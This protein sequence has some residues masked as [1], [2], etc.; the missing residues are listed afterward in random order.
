[1]IKKL[2]R[3]FVVMLAFAA[4]TTA[5]SFSPI[6]SAFA[7]DEA[8]AGTAAEDIQLDIDKFSNAAALVTPGYINVT[9]N[10]KSGTYD[11]TS[12]DVAG[13]LRIGLGG[14]DL[15]GAETFRFLMKSGKATRMKFGFID[16]NGTAVLVD[17]TRAGAYTGI[18]FL[19]YNS[20]PIRDTV[21][22]DL[23]YLGVRFNNTSNWGASYVCLS[24]S[25]FSNALS[26]TTSNG[27]AWGY[28]YS[29]GETGAKIDWTDIDS[30]F[31]EYVSN[32]DDVSWRN[33]YSLD[34]V[35]AEGVVETVNANNLTQIERPAY[36]A[37]DSGYEK[38][39]YSF[40]ARPVFIETTDFFS[41]KAVSCYHT[42]KGGITGTTGWLTDN[43]SRDLTD[44]NAI[45][46][47]VDTT[48][49]AITGETEIQWLIK[50]KDGVNYGGNTYS[51]RIPDGGDIQII[52]KRSQFIPAGYRGRIIIPFT[53]FHGNDTTFDQV[54]RDSVVK[55]LLAFITNGNGVGT[56]S[57]CKIIVK[58]ARY[59]ANFDEEVAAA[60]AAALKDGLAAFCTDFYM[61]DGASI[62]IK[63]DDFGLRF[64]INVG[65]ES[66]TAL[67]EKARNLGVNVKIGALL[68]PTV[69]LTEGETVCELTTQNA[70]ALLTA[71][72]WAV[73]NQ[74]FYA[75]LGYDMVKEH[76]NDEVTVRGYLVL[77]FKDGTDLTV[78]TQQK[79]D[80]EGNISGTGGQVS[81]S[82]MYVAQKVDENFSREFAGIS[83]DGKKYAFE[84]LKQIYPSASGYEP[85][86]R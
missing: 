31:I 48:D 67:K 74:R 38:N 39:E 59:I 22:E 55:T 79:K 61:R 15:S 63:K 80:A 45:S 4:A 43:V 69:S 12:K 30:V 75:T 57:S 40:G 5:C 64:E 85:N 68:A 70:A 56:D 81:R 72:K 3:F 82:V 73:E 16:G 6:L 34:S 49:P 54:E 42:V 51:V 1:M 21:A 58:D 20:E 47:C 14:A 26:F 44:Y 46:F 29:E 33:F 62:R 2:K 27:T 86:G 52:Y 11:A 19:N 76:L 10:K 28:G 7:I 78:Y 8:E 83:E 25:T 66:F 65:E 9:Q 13:T 53:N 36:N 60:Q 84:V 24:K 23:N 37:A 50:G 18:S 35:T 17:H 32:F 41:C 77:T 71:E